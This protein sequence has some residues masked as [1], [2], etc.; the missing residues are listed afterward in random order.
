MQKTT[1]KNKIK[2]KINPL[3]Q[4]K[5]SIKTFNLILKVIKRQKNIFQKN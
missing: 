2:Q 3:K 5:E 1:L 4:N